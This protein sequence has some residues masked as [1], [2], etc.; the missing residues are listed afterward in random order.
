VNAHVL[1]Q[2]V[3]AAELPFASPD[4]AHPRFI[5][6]VNGPDVPFEVLASDE[7]LAAAIDVAGI[8][9]GTLLRLVFT[10]RIDRFT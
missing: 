2:V 6:C 10:A 1:I 3:T 5:V 7:T 9:P 8:C 4:R